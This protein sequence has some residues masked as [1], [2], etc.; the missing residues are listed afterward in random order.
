MLLDSVEAQIGALYTDTES[1]QVW[2]GT[3]L[4]AVLAEAFAAME[5]TPS[6]L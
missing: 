1:P 5:Q 6:D 2:Y 4:K 3:Q